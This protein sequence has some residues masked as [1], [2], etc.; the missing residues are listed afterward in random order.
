MKTFIINW[1]V[2]NSGN[3]F[4]RAAIVGPYRLFL[5]RQCWGL[6]YDTPTTMTELRCGTCANILA[7]RKDL[8]M[9]LKEELARFEAE[10]D[11][12]DPTTPEALLIDGACDGDSFA[13]VEDYVKLASARGGISLDQKERVELLL[14]LERGR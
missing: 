14:M 9:T 1:K 6:F 8:L 12:V 11:V 10:C 7:S 3:R 5:N 13:T 4:R 2:L